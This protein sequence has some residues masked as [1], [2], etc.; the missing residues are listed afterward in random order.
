M[1]TGTRYHGDSRLHVKLHAAHES[2]DSDRLD[3][4]TEQ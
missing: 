1:Q 3:G 2:N 4:D